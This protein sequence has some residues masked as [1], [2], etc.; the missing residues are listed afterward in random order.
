MEEAFVVD[1]EKPSERPCKIRNAK[2]RALNRPPHEKR[3]ALAHHRPDR[4]FAE[5]RTSQFG[6]ER[7]GRVG[8]IATRVDQRAVEIEDDVLVGER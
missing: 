8:E 7:V 6:D 2:T 1:F 5:R 4:L 3:G